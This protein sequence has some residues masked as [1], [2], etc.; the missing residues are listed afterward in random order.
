VIKIKSITVEEVPA[1]LYVK[2]HGQKPVCI[3]T[4]EQGSIPG[5]DRAITI[6]ANEED[7]KII[8]EAIADIATGTVR[9]WT[10]GAA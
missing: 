10:K 9:P 4:N 3:F 6:C 7:M 2:L 1:G 5:L 8:G